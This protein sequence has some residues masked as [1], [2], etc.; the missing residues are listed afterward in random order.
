MTAL[1]AARDPTAAIAVE[2]IQGVMVE[3]EGRERIEGLRS[4]TLTISYAILPRRRYVDIRAWASSRSLIS[5]CPWSH[6]QERGHPTPVGRRRVSGRRSGLRRR[7]PDLEAARCP[8]MPR[9]GTLRGLASGGSSG[10]R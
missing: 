10:G 1:T 3:V 6:D 8:S 5:P 4:A 2:G 9:R 7:T